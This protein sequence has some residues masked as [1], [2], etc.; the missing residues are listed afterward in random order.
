MAQ[1]EKGEGQMVRRFR[2]SRERFVFAALLTAF[3]VIGIV[4]AVHLISAQSGYAQAQ[5]EYD[6]LRLYAPG[7]LSTPVPLSAQ[8]ETPVQDTPAP[9]TS[10]RQTEPEPPRDLKSI[11]PD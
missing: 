9:G 7:V 5:D 1:V 8:V 4:A 3:T 11:N 2:F 10:W 6:T